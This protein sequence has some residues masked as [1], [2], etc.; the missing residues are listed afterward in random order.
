MAYGIS[1]GIT[2]LDFTFKVSDDLTIFMIPMI[3]LILLTIF[4]F[5]ER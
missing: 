4:I 5:L 3:Y 1:Q 2:I